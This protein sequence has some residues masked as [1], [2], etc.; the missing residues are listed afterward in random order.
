MSYHNQPSFVLYVSYQTMHSTRLLVR[1]RVLIISRNIKL[2]PNVLMIL[3]NSVFSIRPSCL[4]LTESQSEELELISSFAFQVIQ[5]NGIHFKTSYLNL[6]NHYIC[7]NHPNKEK[8]NKYFILLFFFF[9]LVKCPKIKLSVSLTNSS[10]FTNNYRTI[11]IEI[12][13]K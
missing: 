13:T 10:I 4:L 5:E 3:W 7:I 1:N 2:D 11:R 8:H 6:P 9:L 12:Q